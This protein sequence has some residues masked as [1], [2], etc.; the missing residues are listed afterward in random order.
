ML[1]AVASYAGVVFLG[2]YRPRHQ[3]SAPCR[4]CTPPPHPQHRHQARRRGAQRH[5]NPLRLQGQA[6]PEASPATHAA[7]DAAWVHHKFMWSPEAQPLKFLQL[8]AI[9]VFKGNMR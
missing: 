2:G 7:P 9:R 8:H 4:H 5:L 3:P 1:Q 6:L